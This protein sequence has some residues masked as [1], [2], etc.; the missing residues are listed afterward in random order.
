MSSSNVAGRPDVEDRA[1][2]LPGMP[3]GESAEEV[4]GCDWYAWPETRPVFIKFMKFEFSKE[5]ILN[6]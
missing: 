4:E 2:L 1:T 6:I 3:R 5:L